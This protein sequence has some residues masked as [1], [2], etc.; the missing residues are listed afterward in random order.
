MREILF[1]GKSKI[2]GEWVYGFYSGENCSEIFSPTFK[3]DNIIIKGSGFWV[4]VEAETVGEYTGLTDANCVRI[5]EGDIINFNECRGIIKF[6]EY[7]NSWEDEDF[8]LG[9]YVDWIDHAFRK[10]F[11]L[12]AKKR[13]IQVVGNIHDNPE[14]LKGADNDEQHR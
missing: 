8:V 3:Q 4:E 2:N 7:P 13:T 9:F 14:L 11:V 6:G 10:D 5:F 12:W 1:R